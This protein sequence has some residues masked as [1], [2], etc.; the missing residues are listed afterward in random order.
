MFSIANLPDKVL[1][2]NAAPDASAAALIRAAVRQHLAKKDAEGLRWL[3]SHHD[4][5][6][7]VLLEICDHG[8]CLDELGHR[9]GP[10]RLVEKM[11]DDHHYPEAIISLALELYVSASEP[12]HAFVA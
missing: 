10:R 4:T 7:D 5:P 2:I 3:C 8:L 12:D 6:E 9:R 11:A 1:T